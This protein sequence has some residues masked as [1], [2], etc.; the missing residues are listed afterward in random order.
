MLAAVPDDV[1]A[2]G[3]ARP[4]I[5]KRV[6][7][8]IHDD[9]AHDWTVLEMAERAGLGVR[10]LQDGFRRY[11]GRSPTKYLADVRLRRVREDLTQA[12]PDDTVRSIALRWGFAHTGRFAATYRDRFGTVPSDALRSD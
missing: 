2:P 5:V 9:P 7:D 11:V 12:G 4:R 8:A 1:P 10:R 6:I 3:E